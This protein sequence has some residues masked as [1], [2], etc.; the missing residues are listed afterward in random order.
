SESFEVDTETLVTIDPISDTSDN[1]PHVSGTGEPGATITIMNGTTQVGTAVVQPNGSW[2]A[3]LDELADGDHTLTV[4]AKDDFDNTLSTSSESFE[5]DTTASAPSME[6]TDVTGNEDTEIPLDISAAL[7]DTD[8]SETLSAI[9]IG[10]VPDGAILSA[11]TNNGDGTWTLT[12]DQLDGLTIKPP[13]D[14][15]V[16]FDLTVTA[17]ATEI[18]GDTATVTESLHVTVTP[19]ADVP[20][21]DFQVSSDNVVSDGLVGHWVFEENGTPGGT[22]HDLVNDQEGTLTGGAHSAGSDHNNGALVLDGDGDYVDVSGDYTEPLSGTATLSVWVKLPD[23]YTG[24][25]GTNTIGW[26]SP[27]IIG[28]EKH[29]GTDDIQWGWI[30][31]DGQINMGVGDSTGAGSTTAVNDGEWHHVVMTRDHETGETKMYVDGILEDTRVTEPGIRDGMDLSGFGATFGSDGTHTYLEGQLDDIRVYDR[32]LTDEEISQIHTYESNQSSFDL[33]GM[34]GDPVSITLGA[35]PTDTD[36]SES[37]TSIVLSGIPTGAILSD[38]T[39]TFTATDDLHEMNVTDWDL[40]N[41]TITAYANAGGFGEP[42]TLT[43]TATSTEGDGGASASTSSSLEIYVMDS[44]PVAVDDTDSVGFRGTA[45]GNVILGEGGEDMGADEVDADDVTLSSISFDGTTYTFAEDGSLMNGSDIVTN[46]TIVGDHGTLQIHQDGS[47]TYT[48]SE[49][50]HPHW[51]NLED[52]FDY[53]ITD[54]DGDSSTA[55]VTIRHDNL[56]TVADSAVAHEAGLPEGTEAATDSETVTGNLLDNDMGVDGDAFISSITSGAHNDTEA[57]GGQLSI[58]TD[59]GTITVYTESDGL[60]RAGDY[61]YTLEHPSQGDDVVDTISY[62]ISD[63]DGEQLTGSLAVNIQDDTPTGETVT[64][65][66]HEDAADVKTTNLIIV[67]DRSGSMAFDM[68]GNRENSPDF[69]PNNVRMDIAKD[70]LAAMFDSY[71]NLGNVNIQFVRFENSAVKSDWFMDDKTGANT[72]LN[73]IHAWGGTDYDGALDTVR[74]DFDPPEADSTLLYFISDGEPNRGDECDQ[75]EWEN[76]LQGE[77]SS[78]DTVFGIGITEDSTLEALNPIAWPNPAD[79]NDPDPHVVQVHNAFDLKQ[80]L[81]ETVSEGIVKGDAT[82]LTTEGNDGIHLGADGGHLQ[83]ILVDGQL[84]TYDP[85]GSPTESITTAR[86]GIIDI[87]FETGEYFYTINPHDTVSG[88]QEVFVLTAVD[89][90]GDTTSVD[91]IINL[92][93]VAAIDANHDTIITNAALGDDLAIDF[94]A[95]LANDSGANSIDDG[96]IHAEGNTQLTQSSDQVTLHDLS[97]GDA[98]TYD[99]SSGDVSDTAKAEVVVED[100][101]NLYGTIGDDILVNTRSNTGTFTINADIRKGFTH[102]SSN[103]MGIQFTNNAS[104]SILAVTIDLR[105]GVDQDAVFDPS[106]YYGFGPYIGGQTSGISSDDVTFSF[107]E[108]HSQMTITFAPGSFSSQDEFRFGIDTDLLNN[109]KGVDYGKQD[110]GITVSLSDGTEVSGTYDHQG[111]TSHVTIDGTTDNAPVHL[112]GNEGDDVL[113]GN[114]ADEILDGGQGHDTIYGGGGD[115]TIVFD[116]QDT[117]I[118]G[119][120]GT[121]TLKIS[122]DVLDFSTLTKDSVT[123]IE[124]LD[125]TSDN[126]QTVSLTL[127]NVL[128][129]TGPENVLHV[130]GG[131]G[132]QVTVD[133]SNSGDGWTHDGNGLFSNTDGTQVQIV[134]VDDADKHIPIF[135]DD[136]TAI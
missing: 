53:T 124:A 18:G 20:V 86:G 61:E 64:A 27:S 89:G 118:D 3:D 15:D 126:A 45:T 79:P 125:L 81:L 17:T 30:D 100:N 122:Q 96:S 44:A 119:G 90:D 34:E 28:S 110:V 102:H 107:S 58:Q 68:D 97:D 47:Y 70:A 46:N 19:I 14:S 84:H 95:L 76:F 66:I 56:S 65:D 39:H 108:D 128:D 83:S 13:A 101:A 23:G 29:G 43:A 74:H 99:I 37:I 1:T 105:A 98:F 38:G 51:W 6:T 42:Y 88:E 136:G 32:V 121:D 78:I 127:E 75:T 2:E 129:M 8:G 111:N 73:D 77:G 92:D 5:V 33:V 85:S 16:D 114:D 55:S 130:S 9:T 104:L 67:L 57:S 72:Y 87:N 35:Q 82:L 69:D 40:S 59:H 116:T 93:Y 26:N 48:S 12:Q 133:L 22:T 120:E 4:I 54:S 94:S 41:L 117:L 103:Q 106:G 11:G 63:S 134:S 131:D 49:H 21:I 109:D 113:I 115:D 132:D 80:T 36:G 31:D 135:T 52:S 7:T 112:Y 62:T 50:W 10:G 24:G 91:L 123:N 25:D 60:H 71:D